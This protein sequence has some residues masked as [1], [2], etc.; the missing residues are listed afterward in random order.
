MKLDRGNASDYAAAR[1]AHPPCLPSMARSSMP[2]VYSKGF[3]V[4]DQMFQAN[5]RYT[6]SSA[7]QFGGVGPLA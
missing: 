1:A 7:R 2:A 5:L 3:V 4:V 6:D